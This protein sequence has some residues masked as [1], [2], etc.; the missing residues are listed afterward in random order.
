M[1]IPARS[2]H[3][4]SVGADAVVLVNSSSAKYL[5]FK[6][7]IQPYLDN[8]G[9]PYTVLD[10]AS[11]TVGTNVGN[12]AVI[13]IGH[14]QLDTNHTYLDTTE[15]QNISVAVT[16]GAGL[17]NFDNDLFAAGTNRYVFV[18]NIFGFTN[19][20]ATAGA[21]VTFPATEPGSQLHYIT[22]LHLASDSIA[23]RSS[24]S[25]AGITFSTNV[26]AVVLSSGK[27]LVAVRKYGQGRAVQWTSYGWMPT[28][29]LGP[30]EG[31]DDLVWRSV[32][33]SARKP[34][35]MR[36]LPHFVTMRMDDT[37]GPFTWVH[38][39]NEM[40]FK[41]WL[42]LFWNSIT[43]TKA[44]DLK[45]LTQA[46]N[47]TA[48]MHAF[49]CCSKFFFWDDFSG[50]GVAGT[51]WPDGVM[52]SNMLAAAR[53]H[54]NHGIP[55][56]KV[57]IPHF[58]EMGLNSVTNLQSWG[59]EYIGNLIL[60]R[61]YSSSPPWPI[62]GP[63]RLYE[64]PGN[65]A[66]P[67][68][69][70][71]AD[72]L[73]V[74]GHPELNG[75]YFLCV[76]ELRDD[77]CGEWCPDNN[78]ADTVTR[79]V[80]QLRREMDGMAIATLYT[81]EW[82][83][84]P[85]PGSSNQTPITTNNWRAILQ[86]ITNSLA[87]YH[88]SYVTLDYACQYMRATRTSRL[89]TGSYD[90]SSGRVTVILSG[91]TDMDTLVY[92]FGGADNGI[93]NGFGTV[94]AFA[95]GPVTNIVA[96][97]LPP[98]LTVTAS[99]RIKTYG[100]TM[101]FAGTEFL[102]S[103]LLGGDIVSN[104]SLSS[105]GTVPGAPV[106]GSPYNIVVANAVGTGLTNYT[107]NYVNGQLTVTAAG[108]TV[109]AKN[110]NR[111]YG[112]TNPVFTASYSGFVDG[113][114][115]GV[116]S[117]TPSLTTVAVTNSPAGSYTITNATGSL[118]A[119]NYTFNFVNGTLTVNPAALTVIA[120]N[121]NK[122]Y[123]QTMAFTGTEFTSSGLV[124]GDTVSSATLTSSG[125]VATAGVAGSPYAI[126]ATNATGGG[127][128]NYMIN[129]QPG[130][131]T[132]NPAALT[133]TA[134]NRSK[135]Y[136]QTMTFAGTEF[137]SSGLVNGDTVS[138]ATLTSS[139]AVATAG[140]AGSPYAINATNATGG[141]LA[142]YMINYQPGILTVNPAA[143][144]VTADDQTRMYGLTNPVLTA[145]YNGFTN[146]EG[147]NVLNGS[148][149]LNT[150]ANSGSIVG[151]YP[152]MITPGTLNSTNY[153]FL[154]KDGTLTVTAAPAPVILSVGLTNQVITVTWSSIAGVPYGLQCATNLSDT[155]WTTVSS[156]LTATG[157]TTS[158]TNVVGDVPCQFYRVM[159]L[160]DDPQS[161]GQ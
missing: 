105:M 157:T 133:V 69:V 144:T 91:K 143:L 60:D 73:S 135:V 119:A 114:T 3:A 136:G 99:N 146:N 97:L 56:S 138:S 49:D 1:Q 66:G 95:S 10:I 161:D 124:N 86:G 84:E 121:T 132:V 32:V 92:V 155:G 33:W 89:V 113:D 27:P 160:Q 4:A 19:A 31:L 12:Y 159:I 63:Y 123:G 115:T 79:G 87:A 25:V 62:A 82:Y 34:F 72:F 111:L 140:V 41:P 14:C 94:P 57:V 16:N 127:L 22:A 36:G 102:T 141:G 40:G 154:F 61:A 52:A 13:I 30:M 81:H 128:A 55:I 145:S 2:L 150:T 17:V 8:F 47:A 96:A 129:Y 104:A 43:D 48:S 103:G 85:I 77:A 39:A 64:T 78:V 44:L 107:I 67:L 148:P 75:K 46:G 125:A 65:N 90:P 24:M 116:L 80:R 42:G 117:G 83:I 26:T 106:N 11:N 6:H 134:S 153:S 139:G 126:N 112:A 70:Y 51:N 45:S 100:Q 130:I 18:R 74:S 38:I 158:Q 142:N 88:P 137:T 59:V 37:S 5:D 71:Y 109:V 98:V 108:L 58:G 147:T 29:M 21:N 7:S 23:F 152:I 54:T 9:I 122:V 50:N 156:N 53:W 93:T 20:S 118:S 110:T 76:T 68:P 131:L 28:A 120:K 15:Q 151:D 35:V 101:V 149:A